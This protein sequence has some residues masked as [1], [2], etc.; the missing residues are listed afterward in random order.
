MIFGEV[1]ETP[2]VGTPLFWGNCAVGAV[3]SGLSAYF[4]DTAN[5]F[6]DTGTSSF[7]NAGQEAVLMG[8]DC[9]ELL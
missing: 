2:V 5:Y 6:I 7:K 3:G 4:Y 9:Q 8:T 1:A